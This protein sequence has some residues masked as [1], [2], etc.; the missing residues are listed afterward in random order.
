MRFISV[1][2]IVFKISNDI[3]Q[4]ALFKNRARHIGGNPEDGRWLVAEWITT[5]FASPALA[6]WL[7]SLTAF[8][9]K[10]NSFRA[11][12]NCCRVS[13]IDNNG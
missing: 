3:Y 2:Q 11:N 9:I 5:L 8:L 4:Y 1:L 6:R 10:P 12:L 13:L 7:A